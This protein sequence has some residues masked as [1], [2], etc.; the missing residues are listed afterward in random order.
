MIKINYRHYKNI[1]YSK[2]QLIEHNEKN[3]YHLVNLLIKNKFF[4]FF[5]CFIAKPTM[6]IT[7]FYGDEL[8][9]AMSDIR[10]D[11]AAHSQSQIKD[12]EEFYRIK[13][14]KFNKRLIK[15]VN[16]NVQ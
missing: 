16:V 13:Q 3:F 9:H 15:K 10:Q 4:D 12:L 11:F 8:A 2:M 5:F 14:N 7:E 6:D 1:G